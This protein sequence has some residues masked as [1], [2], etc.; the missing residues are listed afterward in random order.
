MEERRVSQDP[1]LA[2][3]AEAIKALER[4][5]E[6]QDLLN[7][8]ILEELKRQNDAV[9]MRNDK[10]DELI[11]AW[12]AGNGILRV[13]KWAAIVGAAMGTI[14]AALHGAKII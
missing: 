11:N 14:W 2:E 7:Q 5:Q 9:D 6:K 13:I 3:L 4:R 8:K 10:L 1:F 12:N